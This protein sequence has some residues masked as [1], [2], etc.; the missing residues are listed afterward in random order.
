MNVKSLAT[1]KPRVDAGTVELL[2]EA[3]AMAKEG[4][5]TGVTLCIERNDR[6]VAYSHAG[7]TDRWK[8]SGMLYHALH[9]LQSD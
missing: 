1:V 5:V 3:L 7:I 2:E 6:S 8:L 4:M 9:K